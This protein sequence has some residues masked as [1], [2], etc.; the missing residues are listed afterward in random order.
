MY[1]RGSK[2]FFV[3]RYQL[4]LPDGSFKWGN[5]KSGAGEDGFGPVVP[6]RP[7]RYEVEV[8]NFVCGDKF[9]FFAKPVVR[10]VSV[11]AGEIT[12]VTISLDLSAEPAKKTIDNQAGARCTASPGIP[13]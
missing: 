13:K 10:P 7:G 6:S 5:F 9:W 12:D 1:D 3:T 8:E 11:K 4:H 2:K